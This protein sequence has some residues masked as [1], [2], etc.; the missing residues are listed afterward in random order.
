[1]AL[2]RHASS[3]FTVT[4]REKRWI[5]YGYLIFFLDKVLSFHPFL[6]S[7]PSHNDMVEKGTYAGNIGSEGTMAIGN[8]K[9]WSNCN[10]ETLWT[11]NRYLDAC[12]QYAGTDRKR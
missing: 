12:T 3:L 4:F 10:H 1:M 6:L 11:Y 9:I 8:M 5:F 2:K 7:L